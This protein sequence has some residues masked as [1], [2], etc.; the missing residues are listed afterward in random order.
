[1]TSLLLLHYANIEKNF[2]ERKVTIFFKTTDACI[3]LLATFDLECLGNTVTYCLSSHLVK[4]VQNLQQIQIEV[5]Q[6]LSMVKYTRVVKRA[7]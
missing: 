1:M 2:I 3:N 6:S 7:D 4:F 5:F